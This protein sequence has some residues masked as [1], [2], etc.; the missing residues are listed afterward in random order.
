MLLG[1]VLEADSD[2]PPNYRTLLLLLVIS[3]G[4]NN[5][6]GAVTDRSDEHG[7]DLMHLET[8][9]GEAEAAFAGI[10]DTNNFLIDSLLQD[11]YCISPIN[12]ICVLY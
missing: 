3:V 2:E 8:G 9:D 1:Q 5:A 10:L 7:G 11:I 6:A 4:I 12:I